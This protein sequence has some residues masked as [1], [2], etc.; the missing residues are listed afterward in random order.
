MKKGVQSPPFFFVTCEIARRLE[1]EGLHRLPAA[2]VCERGRP[3]DDV[4]NSAPKSCA[5]K[6]GHLR[7]LHTLKPAHSQPVRQAARKGLARVQAIGRTTGPLRAETRQ[8]GIFRQDFTQ[9]GGKSPG[10]VQRWF[11]SGT[12]RL[13]ISAGRFS[14]K[15]TTNEGGTS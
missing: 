8:T 4:Q 3:A 11:R 9:R 2:N 14:M 5:S 13:S 1:A 12:S 15:E 10:K 7:L 6:S